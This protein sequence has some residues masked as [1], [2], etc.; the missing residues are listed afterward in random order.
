MSVHARTW[1]ALLAEKKGP[2]RGHRSSQLVW[3]G[4]AGSGVM[5]SVAWNLLPHSAAEHTEKSP[6][7]ASKGC[8]VLIREKLLSQG[9]V[10]SSLGPTSPSSLLESQTPGEGS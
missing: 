5:A 4:K 2:E 9:W 6:L 3:L 8:S 10:R 7:Q 1:S